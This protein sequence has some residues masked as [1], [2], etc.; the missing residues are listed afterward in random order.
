[1]LLVKRIQFFFDEEEAKKAGYED[2]P[3]PPT[4]GTLMN[5]W[6]Y[7][8]IWDR[9]KELGVN[10]QRLLHASEAYE[11]FEPIYPGDV[12]AGVVK[13]DSLRSSSNMDIA[14]F[15][16]TYT[17]DGKKVLIANMKIVVMTGGE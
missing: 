8:E 7:P 3:V 4:F 1:M 14:S 15:K 16:T 9:M 17:R 2:T 5:F 10:V 6:G 11:Y 12:I 13:V